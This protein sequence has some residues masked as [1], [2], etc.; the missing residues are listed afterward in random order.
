MP[1]ENVMFEPTERDRI[2]RY[3]RQ[4]C[5]PETCAAI[6][7]KI[8]A[9][10][11]KDRD[12]AAS[13]IRVLWSE[14]L[15]EPTKYETDPEDGALFEVPEPKIDSELKDTTQFVLATSGYKAVDPLFL[16]QL[17]PEQVNSGGTADLSATIN[18]VGNE[19]IQASSIINDRLLE[20]FRKKPDKMLSLSP[21][22][23]E[24]LIAELFLREGFSVEITPFVK[25]SGKD[26]IAVKHDH[27]GTH[28]YFAECK[29]YAPQYP[30]GVDYVRSLYG[31]V[32]LEKATKG[33][34]ATT[35]Y[36][37]SG[38]EKFAREV[39]YRI[40]LNDYDDI[41]DWLNKVVKG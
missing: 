39:K 17:E 12:T 37:T 14:G 8:L 32:E 31:I 21:R 24:E 11:F 33:I 36:F 18:V 40:G 38:A 27:L 19:I 28:L 4:F 22:E 2:L 6:T 30:V 13:I 23:F 20:E 3:V 29:R 15:I 41:K 26:I 35:S 7:F 34:L 16:S 9:D 5:E 25:D 10:Q 1:S